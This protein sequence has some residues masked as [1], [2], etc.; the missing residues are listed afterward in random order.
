MNTLAEYLSCL[1]NNYLLPTSSLLNGDNIMFKLL[2]FIEPI[3]GTVY[4]I[5]Y[6]KRI[7]MI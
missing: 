6:V 3:I 4:I 5:Y 2:Y 7:L 1:L